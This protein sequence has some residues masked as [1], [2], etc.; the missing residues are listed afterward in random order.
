MSINVLGNEVTS[1]DIYSD[2]TYMS[3]ITQMGLVL[4]LDAGDLNSYPGS[5][6]TWY[7]LSGKGHNFTFG[8]NI[9]WNA[10]GYFNCTGG[11]FLGPAS[12]ATSWGFNERCEHYIEI[13]CD[14]TSFQS[15]WAFKFEAT[16]SA[17]DN[18]AI[19]SHLGYG[20]SGLSYYDVGGCCAT[21]ERLSGNIS[22]LIGTIN[23]I[24]YQTRVGQNPNRQVY[25]NLITVLDSGTYSGPN[26]VT[27]N[28]TTAV[29]LFDAWLGKAY[30]IRVNNRPLHPYE[31]AENF[32]AT[33][34]RCGL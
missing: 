3:G 34:G 12:N 1:T 25:Q 23:C 18:R 29:D 26:Y 33:R 17:F 5:G 15:N 20:A 2:G 21:S 13:Y 30:I 16:S 6:S 8:A 4:N 14:M 9:A 24:S 7:D 27:W 11:G 10:A 32:Q 19:A 22:N 31:I 28:D